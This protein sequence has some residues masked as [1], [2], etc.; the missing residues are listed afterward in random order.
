[1]LLQALDPNRRCSTASQKSNPGSPK[2][3]QKQPSSLRLI[4]PSLILLSP[5]I[6]QQSSLST[7]SPPITAQV[8]SIILQ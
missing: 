5:V 6:S 7:P 8:F 3:L 4:Q 2:K 1:M